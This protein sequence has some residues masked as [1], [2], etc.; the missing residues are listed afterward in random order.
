MLYTFSYMAGIFF[1]YYSS[2]IVT[3]SC[4]TVM[5]NVGLNILCCNVLEGGRTYIPEQLD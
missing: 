2:F 5:G 1:Y 4:L 3:Q